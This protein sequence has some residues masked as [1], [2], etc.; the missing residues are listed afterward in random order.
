MKRFQ[1]PLYTRKEMRNHI[2]FPENVTPEREIPDLIAAT[3][4]NIPHTYWKSSDLRFVSVTCHAHEQRHLAD[5]L[6]SVLNG[7]ELVVLWKP[8]VA[9]V[10]PALLRLATSQGWSLVR[11]DGTRCRAVRSAIDKML[12]DRDL[13]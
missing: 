10:R 2:L 6:G 8:A 9:E 1:E 4:G 7:W 11:P 12:R 5:A 13:R 3:F